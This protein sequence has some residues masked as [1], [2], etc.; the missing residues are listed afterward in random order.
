MSILSESLEDMKGVLAGG[1]IQGW[2]P[3]VAVGLWRRML[4]TLGG[5][6]KIEDSENLT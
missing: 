5:I 3:D 6:N 2:T 4:G 1:V